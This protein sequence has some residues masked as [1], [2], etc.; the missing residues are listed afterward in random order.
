MKINENLILI[1]QLVALVP[2]KPEHVPKY[3]EWMKNPF[4]QEMTASEPLSLEEEYEMQQS[5]HQD[6]KKLTFIITALPTDSPVH[7]KDIPKEE[8]K[9][10]T[11]MIGD[12]N[13]FFNDPDDDPTFGEIEVMIA[14]ADYR[15]TGRGREA[16]RI[17][18]GYAMEELGVKTFH[19]KISLKNEPSI[20]LF[21]SKFGYYPVSVS[22]IFQ[23]TTLEWSLL[24]NTTSKDHERIIKVQQEILNFFHNHVDSITWQ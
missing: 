5:W 15:K 8:V 2:Y 23:E 4:L 3:H 17:M 16:L 10:K 24:D 12:V 11:V 1:G 22:E 21:E 19:A 13:I 14:E 6:D 7:L 18:M 9:D 20:Q